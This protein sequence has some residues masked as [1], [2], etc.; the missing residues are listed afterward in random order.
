MVRF[1]AVSVW[2]ESEMA[3]PFACHGMDGQRREAEAVDMRLGRGINWISDRGDRG[4][5]P[6]HSDSLT[7]LHDIGPLDSLILMKHNASKVD[8]LAKTLPWLDYSSAAQMNKIGFF[9]FSL[10]STTRCPIETVNCNLKNQSQ[11]A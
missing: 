7:Q 5:I 3:L 1:C 9:F 4:Q 11:R 6:R 10:K 2:W 8:G